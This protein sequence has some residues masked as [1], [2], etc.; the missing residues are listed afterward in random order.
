MRI[1]SDVVE[2]RQEAELLRRT[3]KKIALVPTMGYLH[4][5]HLRLIEHA[6]R[7]SDVVV[8]SSFVN[9]M[10]FGPN[11]DFS[12]YPRDFERDKELALKSGVD[13]LFTPTREDMFTAEFGTYVEEQDASKILEGSIRPNHF[14]GVT[15]V[16]AKLFNICKPHTAV[17]GQK[18]VQQVFIVK[19]MVHDLN[20][21]VSIVVVPIVREPDGLALSSRNVYLSGAERSN[22]VV[23]NES[24]KF[25]EDRIRNG[26]RD[27]RVLLSHMQRMIVS[28]GSPVVDYI[29]FIDPDVFR[30]I[31]TIAKPAVLIAL[32]VRFGSTRL[33][34]N[35]LIRVE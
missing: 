3:G 5:G 18:D 8:V 12:R 29:A 23:L 1:V 9:P 7:M 13:V 2:M 16:V 15:T 10:Q 11:E 27:V 35:A 20:V 28:K 14:R 34:D 4:E 26:E 31:E 17:F 24:L 21:D 19:K 25:A 30:V 22:A 33:I 6:R 32:A